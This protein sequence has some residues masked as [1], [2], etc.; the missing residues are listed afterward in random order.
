MKKVFVHLHNEG[1]VNWI[2]EYYHF[3]RIPSEGE[4]LATEFNGDWYKV[5]LVVHTPFTEEMSADIYAV[6]VNHSEEMKKKFKN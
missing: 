3:D 5:A 6:K 2:N 4:Y 1:E